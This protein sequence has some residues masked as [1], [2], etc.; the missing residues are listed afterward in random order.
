MPRDP[1]GPPI[2]RSLESRGATINTLVEID[3]IKRRELVRRFPE[4]KVYEDVQDAEWTAI[5][6]RPGKPRH[7]GAGSRS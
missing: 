3:P 4:A 2:E 1:N 6:W 5:H 7:A